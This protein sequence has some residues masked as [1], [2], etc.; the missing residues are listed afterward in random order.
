[1]STQRSSNTPVRILSTSADIPVIVHGHI[2]RHDEERVIIEAGSGA[3]RLAEGDRVVLSLENAGNKISGTVES[4]SPC[5][6]GHQIQVFCAAEHDADKR[7]FPR[8]HAGLPI[9][10]R[11][12]D[13]A[14]AAAW[15]A[16]EAA[17][18]DGWQVPDPFMNFSV[19]GLRFDAVRSVQANDLLLIDFATAEDGPRWRLTARVIRAFEPESEDSP[20]HSVAVAF[21]HYPGAANEVLS[22]LTLRIQDTLL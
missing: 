8:L 22:E 17:P 10:Y 9:R 2:T 12:A 6:A 4:I 20:T 5:E 1:M 11:V 13:D 16:D 21:V 3:D 7:D 19:G 14:D 15:I 18:D